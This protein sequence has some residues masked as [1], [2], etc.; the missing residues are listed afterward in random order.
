MNHEAYSALQLKLLEA[1]QFLAIGDEAVARALNPTYV[2]DV[3]AGRAES[4]PDLL[5]LK[6]MDGSRRLRLREV[7]FKL[8]ERLVVK[9]VTQ[10]E[11]GL[12]LLRQ[13]RSGLAPAL[14]IDR[15][16]IVVVLRDRKLK[17]QEK[18][19]LGEPLG[20]NRFELRLRGKPC[21][22]GEGDRSYPVTVL[23]L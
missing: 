18:P 10:L 12:R 22:L 4:L 20:P 9:A 8:E 16:E 21:R 13:N 3:R 5:S 15:T 19:F 17:S 23:L 1:E 2:D 7:K 6:S 11:S 14:E